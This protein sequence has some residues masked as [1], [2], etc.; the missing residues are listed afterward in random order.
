MRVAGAGPVQEPVP[1]A[2]HSSRERTGMPRQAT[3]RRFP[4]CAASAV[5]VLAAVDDN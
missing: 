5:Q 2:R 3:L 4:L 1:E